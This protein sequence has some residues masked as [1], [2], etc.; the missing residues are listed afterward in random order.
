MHALTEEPDPKA[1]AQHVLST[2]ALYLACGLDPE[3]STL[4]VQSHVAAHS[5]LARLLGSITSVGTLKR[6]IQFK[7]KSVKSGQ[8]ASL[9]LLDYPVLMAADILLYDA[10][11]VPVGADQKQH[12]ELT[13]EIASRFNRLYGSEG[14]QLLSIPAP[15]VVAETAKVMSLTDGTRKMSKSDSNDLSRINMMDSPEV[16]RKKIKVAKTD[17][18]RG[19]EFDNPERPDVHNLLTLYCVLSGKSREEVAGE[20]KEMGYGTFKPLLA[21]T[22]ISVLAPIQERYKLLMEEPDRVIEVIRQGRKRATAVADAT[23]ARAS[24]AMGLTVF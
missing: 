20:C 6:M 19:L 7:E 18:L 10:D 17:S 23:L 11:L 1:L 14:K 4:F 12:L 24:Q 2:A 15:L 9:S 5:Q 3:K 8:D 13:R 16:I 22:I 21:E